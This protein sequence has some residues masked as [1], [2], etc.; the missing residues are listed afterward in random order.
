FWGWVW[1]S[2]VY[3]GGAHASGPM[4][5]LGPRG[6]PFGA[7][8]AGVTCPCSRQGRGHCARC[9][10]VLTSGPRSLE[11]SPHARFDRDLE[12]AGQGTHLSD[13]RTSHVPRS[14]GAQPASVLSLLQPGLVVGLLL[15]LVLS[16]LL[17]ALW[18]Y[19]RRAY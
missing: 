13:L 17:Y 19:R 1:R 3:L 12:S 4:L 10:T 8:R 15:I 2:V 9:P 5:P 7:P 18:P 16:Q 11:R 6:E 14:G